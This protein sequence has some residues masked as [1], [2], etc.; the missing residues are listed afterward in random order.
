MKRFLNIIIC[1]LF[2]P[3]WGGQVGFVYAEISF[4]GAW[5]ATVANIDWPTPEAVGNTSKQQSEMIF[6]LD[7]L[8]SIGINAMRNHAGCSNHIK[9]QIFDYIL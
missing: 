6:L 4:R 8:Q 5:I 2:L 7:S 1:F 3:L 9:I